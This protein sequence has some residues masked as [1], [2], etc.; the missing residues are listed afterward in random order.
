M[1]EEDILESMQLKPQNLAVY[2]FDQTI[3]SV[4]RHATKE[5]KIPKV[6][7]VLRDLTGKYIW[8]SQL[9][10]PA[11]ALDIEETH[12]PKDPKYDLKPPKSNPELSE[13]DKK[14]LMQIMEL[15]EPAEKRRHDII[16]EKAKQRESEENSLLQSKNY[17]LGDN[18]VAKRPRFPPIDQS[19]FAVSPNRLW[20]THL[21]FLSLVNHQRF[22]VVQPFNAAA[23]FNYVHNFKILDQ[24][25]ERDTYSAAVCFTKGAVTEEEIFENNLGS[26]EYS[27]FVNSVGWS[28][29]L[30]DHKGY[31]GGLENVKVTGEYAPYS[32]TYDYEM[33][34]HVFTLMPSVDKMAHKKRFLT[35]DKVLISWVEDLDQYDLKM[36]KS[37]DLAINIVINPLKSG[38]F[39]IRI[40]RFKSW[41][42][43]FGPLL[44]EMVVNKNSLA[45]LTRQTAVNACKILREDKTKA[46]A[47]RKILIDDFIQTHKVQFEPLHQ[48][49]ASQFR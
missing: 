38:L 44:D 20:L 39:R 5:A 22:S 43:V 7:I 13:E 31:K 47:K 6:T 46:F 1:S 48:F 49:Y 33:I 2:I 11:P 9:R 14:F 4:I 40:F 35:N 17:G 19:G 29:K 10:Y 12:I 28:V 8:T 3:I 42:P 27:L 36:L 41:I 30:D 18:I 37:F 26:V 45:A 24:T 34:F 16:F 32:A 25:R 15:L 21:G 23:P